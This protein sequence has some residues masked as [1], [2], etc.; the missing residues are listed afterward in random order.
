MGKDNTL[1]TKIKQQMTRFANGLTKGWGKI[2]QRFVQEMVY[3]IQA[4]KD[5]KLSEVGRALNEEPELIQFCRCQVR[6]AHHWLTPMRAAAG[7]HAGPG[8][9]KANSPGN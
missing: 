5:V 1:P 9:P 8:F 4:A 3:G 2:R 6:E 7:F